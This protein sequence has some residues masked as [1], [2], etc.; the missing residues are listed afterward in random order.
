MNRSKSQLVLTTKRKEKKINSFRP[1][2][3]SANPVYTYK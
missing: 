3:P 1:T 2:P